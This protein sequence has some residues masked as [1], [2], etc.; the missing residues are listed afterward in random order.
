[1]SLELARWRAQ[2]YRDPA[3]A[4]DLRI[5]MRRRRAS[6]SLELQV[7]LA[8][9]VPLVLDWRGPPVRGLRVNGKP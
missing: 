9:R 8:S 6:G 3:Y 2:H 4:L 5:D 7:T 1:M